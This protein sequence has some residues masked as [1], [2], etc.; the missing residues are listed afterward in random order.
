MILEYNIF[1][2]VKDTFHKKRVFNAHHSLNNYLKSIVY[3]NIVISYDKLTKLAKN[4]LIEPGFYR[5]LDSAITT[6]DVKIV[7]IILDNIAFDITERYIYNVVEMDNLEILKLLLERG[8][9]NLL[10]EV[11]QNDYTSNI[12]I[13]LTKHN[14]VY[15]AQ[16]LINNTKLIQFLNKNG[17]KHPFSRC[18]N[19]HLLTVLKMLIPHID[20]LGQFNDTLL[21]SLV[22]RNRNDIVKLL[23]QN[24]SVKNNSLL[25]AYHA[26]I[27]SE[28]NDIF[29][30]LFELNTDHLYSV[31]ISI[32][33]HNFYALDKILRSIN[34]NKY[35]VK[36]YLI[37]DMSYLTEDLNHT[38]MYY[39]TL[40][41]YPSKELKMLISKYPNF[42]NILNDEV[43]NTIRPNYKPKK[44]K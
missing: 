29:D 37:K 6:G 16:Y 44:F 9:D 19:Y 40:K 15:L 18:V 17:V 20:N 7:E 24:D 38:I 21:T 8:G 25:E 13:H 28:N 27:S 43:K 14:R 26:S 3:N 35:M 10:N 1:N 12:V 4:R 39:L 36:S 42:I 22:N 32:Q 41:G 31:I 33:V 30:I 5:I 2:T 34:W 11:T 23:L